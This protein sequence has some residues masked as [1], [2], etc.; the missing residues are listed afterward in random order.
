MSTKNYN[1]KNKL[2]QY[3]KAQTW[4]AEIPASNGRVRPVE[5]KTIEPPPAES[6]PHFEE[7]FRNEGKQAV[8]IKHRNILSVYDFGKYGNRYYIASEYC[9]GYTLS[10]LAHKLTEK[11][12]HLPVWFLLRIIAEVCDGVAHVRTA[13]SNGGNPAA[14]ETF[15][16]N[17]DNIIISVNGSV[18]LCNPGI[19]QLNSYILSGDSSIPGGYF[20]YAPPEYYRAEKSNERAD[21]FSIGLI[22]HELLSGQSNSLPLPLDSMQNGGLEPLITLAPWITDELNEII[23]KAA[24]GDPQERFDS[25]QTFA[26]V[27]REFINKHDVTRD[28][29][30]TGLLVASVFRDNPTIPP[31][32][33]KIFTDWPDIKR[34]LTDAEKQRWGW[35]NT[36]LTGEYLNGFAQSGLM[37]HYLRESVPPGAAA[38][39]DE[40]SPQHN[41]HA[42]QTDGNTR[43]PDIAH[44]EVRNGLCGETGEQ[45]Q[46]SDLHATEES[47]SHAG[48]RPI[49]APQETGSPM[50]GQITVDSKPTGWF[51]TGE[52]TQRDKAEQQLHSLWNDAVSSRDTWA[53]A[54]GTSNLARFFAQTQSMPAIRKD[55]PPTMP[56]P[57]LARSEPGSPEAPVEAHQLHN[58]SDEP[59]ELTEADKYFDDGMHAV[60]RKDF[61]AAI[62]CFEHACRLEPDNKIFL[63]NLRLARNQF[64]KQNSEL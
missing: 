56:F 1:L 27:L 23:L 58:G 10:Y 19:P 47:E 64:E 9:N 36:I 30:E 57:N 2:H 21:V 42:R 5:L 14:G 17:P 52:L 38:T 13:W 63:T 59:L 55:S 46:H 39:A 51:S 41:G 54:P 61:N 12:M 15:F 50:S 43:K 7:L 3:Q 26:I 25:A 11:N 28:P 49:D 40:M 34:R 48:T 20:R 22:M 45:A 53:S 18:K 4:L 35:L 32:V 29:S 16:L 31:T 37:N 6:L 24:S 44:F 62:A 60:H 33:H 8:T